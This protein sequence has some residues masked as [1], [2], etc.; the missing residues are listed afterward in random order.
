MREF[1]RLQFTAEA[2]KADGI[3]EEVLFYLNEE[4]LVSIAEPPFVTETTIGEAGTYQVY[5]RALDSNG[6]NV[7]S[8]SQS[9]SVVSDL[10]SKRLEAEHGILSDSVDTIDLSVGVSGSGYVESK[11]KGRITWKNVGMGS[12]TDFDMKIRFRLSDGINNQELLI[13]DTVVDTLIFEGDT[14]GWQILETTVVAEEAIFSLGLANLDQNIQFDYLDLKASGVGTSN[15]DLLTG[16]KILTLDQNYPNPFNPV[17]VIGYQLPEQS[18]V[19]L[20]VFDMLGRRVALLADGVQSA[21]TYSAEFDA[22]NLASGAYMYRLTA[23]Q[24][25]RVRMMTLIK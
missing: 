23:N 6:Y 8:S 10:S 20:E 9:I 3:I 11:E 18:E 13:N 7:Q 2:T 24:Q 15:E 21:G 4:E 19:R 17:T 22:S 1:S 12:E 14:N 16:P 25:E 5:A